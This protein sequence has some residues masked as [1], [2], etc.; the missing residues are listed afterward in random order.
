MA[1]TQRRVDRLDEKL[2]NAVDHERLASLGAD[3]AAAQRELGAL[4][5]RW[6]EL[7]EQLPG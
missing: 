2:A 6:L 5:D 4:E 7:S 3:L 1:K